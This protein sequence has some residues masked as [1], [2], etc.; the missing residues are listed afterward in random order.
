MGGQL[1]EVVPHLDWQHP[2]FAISPH[3]PCICWQQSCSVRVIFGAA[4]HASTGSFMM[5][6]TRTATMLVR[7]RMNPVKYPSG[8]Q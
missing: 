6:T 5:S 2:C 8:H 1:L 4:A 7:R 3:L